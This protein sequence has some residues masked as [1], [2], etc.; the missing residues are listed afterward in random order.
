MEKECQKHGQQGK[1]AEDRPE[2]G[3]IVDLEDFENFEYELEDADILEL[4]KRK[5]ITLKTANDFGGKIIIYELIGN[6]VLKPEDIKKL[7]EDRKFKRTS[8]KRNICK[9]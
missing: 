3:D 6:E 8:I 9:I 5:A 7:R 4:Y 2:E 1:T